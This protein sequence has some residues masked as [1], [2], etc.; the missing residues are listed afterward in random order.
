MKQ[1]KKNHQ[2]EICLPLLAKKKRKIQNPP[3]TLR[4]EILEP[5]QMLSAVPWLPIGNDIAPIDEAVEETKEAGE[6]VKDA[7]KEATD[8]DN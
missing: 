3:K 6:S 1:Q 4:L 8:D 5:R 2:N 7:V